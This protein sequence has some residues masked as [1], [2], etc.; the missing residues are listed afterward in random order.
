MLLAFAIGF[1]S[2]QTWKAV[3]GFVCDK[4]KGEKVSIGTV[5]RHFADSGG[6]PSGHTA[7]FTAATLCLGTVCGFNSG[8]FMLAVCT[9]MIVVYDATHVR[10]A[11]GEQGVALN[12]LLKAAGKRELEVVRGHTVAQVVVGAV[13]GIAVW[14]LMLLG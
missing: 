14:G 1:L 3:A 7:S 6:M 12:E 9:W 5:I 2:A 4:R 8:V 11:V 10:Y 13:L